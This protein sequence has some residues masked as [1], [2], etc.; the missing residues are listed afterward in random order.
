MRV[1]EDDIALTCQ[2]QEKNHGKISI[3]SE[4]N[5]GSKFTLMLPK[6]K[7]Y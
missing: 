4:P 6:N 5:K 7:M 3:K 2:T 1:I